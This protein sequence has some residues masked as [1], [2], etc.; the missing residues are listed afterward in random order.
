MRSGVPVLPAAPVP[1]NTTSRFFNGQYPGELAHLSPEPAV[2]EALRA[3]GHTGRMFKM[4]VTPRLHGI[5]GYTGLGKDMWDDVGEGE[6]LRRLQ[7]ALANI[8]VPTV[9]GR[10]TLFCARLRARVGSRRSSAL[11][12]RRAALGAPVSA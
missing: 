2:R 3:A 6:D 10:I 1:Q 11:D 8:P 5:R 7:D 9:R 4:G 12:A